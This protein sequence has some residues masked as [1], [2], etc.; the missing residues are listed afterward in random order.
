VP[1]GALNR[2]PCDI[3]TGAP[4]RGRQPEKTVAG[5]SAW[6]SSTVTCLQNITDPFLSIGTFAHPYQP[7]DLRFDQRWI[8]LS[9][10]SG[11]GVAFTSLAG[12]G[13]VTFKSVRIDE[14]GRSIGW[15]RCTIIQQ[16]MMRM[17]GWAGAR[18]R[19]LCVRRLP[20]RRVVR[21]AAC[22]A[23]NLYCRYLV[24]RCGFGGS[25]RGGSLSRHGVSVPIPPTPYR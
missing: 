24:L 1:H 8:P 6:I 11:P 22:S 21:A 3:M 2:A 16:R 20:L 14:N 7:C 17:P 4:S 13:L 5:T 9:N 15:A 18:Q 25:I 19:G 12:S 10:R 23:A